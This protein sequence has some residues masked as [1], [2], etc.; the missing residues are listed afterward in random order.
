MSFKLSYL[1][2]ERVIHSTPYQMLQ[3][4]L[5]YALQEAESYKQNN[6][7]LNRQLMTL[8]QQFQQDKEKIEVAEQSRRELME[9]ELK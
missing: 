2:I 7:K 6:D 5:S 4:Q 8:T 1:P 9:K 3:Q